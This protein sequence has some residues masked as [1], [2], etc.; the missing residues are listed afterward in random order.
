MPE[1]LPPLPA[2]YR[3]E[4][5]NYADQYST[6]RPSEDSNMGVSPNKPVKPKRGH[7]SK[8]SLT[9]VHVSKER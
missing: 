1:P 2:Q 7:H 9:G 8:C 3:T 4:N 5:D 6:F